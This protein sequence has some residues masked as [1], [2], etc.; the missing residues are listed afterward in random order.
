MFRLV[1]VLLPDIF[2]S[3][4]LQLPPVQPKSHLRQSAKWR[5]DGR[6]T[7]RPALRT[8]NPSQRNPETQKQTG[9]RFPP[10]ARSSCNLRA[11]P[12]KGIFLRWK[13][14]AQKPQKAERGVCRYAPASQHE[15]PACTGVVRTG[16]QSI[17]AAHTSNNRHCSV[18]RGFRVVAVWI[19]VGTQ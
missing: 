13:N 12:K 17:Y 16:V 10:P 3:R 1:D 4:V 19:S 18:K 6:E 15:L 7:K 9:I 11:P 8:V 2:L 14:H 5:K